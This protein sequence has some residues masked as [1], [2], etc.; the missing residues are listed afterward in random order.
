MQTENAALQEIFLTEDDQTLRNEENYNIFLQLVI[1]VVAIFTAAFW[2][3]TM[4]EIL[5]NGTLLHSKL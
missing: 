3:S 5:Q 4:F 1:A 2:A